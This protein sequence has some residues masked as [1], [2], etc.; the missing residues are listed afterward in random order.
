MRALRLEVYSLSV[1][2]S[3]HLASS[4]IYFA[5]GTIIGNRVSVV[6][7]A[8]VS[9]GEGVVVQDDVAIDT[10]AGERDGVV[11]A[12]NVDVDAFTVIPRGSTLRVEF[13]AQEG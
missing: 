11:A 5:A 2:H 9:L 6:G 13:G 10:S 3:G 12:V 4:S 7:P 8:A 1:G